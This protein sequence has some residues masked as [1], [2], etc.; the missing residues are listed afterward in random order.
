MKR[1]EYMP[2]GT[3]NDSCE[4]NAS[5]GGKRKEPYNDEVS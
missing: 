4:R 5:C 2:I 3:G 1:S